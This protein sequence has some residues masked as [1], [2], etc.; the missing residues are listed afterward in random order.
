[1]VKYVLKRVLIGILTMLVLITATFFLMHIIP[2]SPFISDDDTAA[3]M[4]AYEALEAKYGLDKPYGE[5]YIIY[6]K[7]ILKGELG[8]SLIRKGQK[9]VDIIA[10]CAP[11]TAKL[12]ATAFIFSMVVGI[13]L[14]TIAAFA[15]RRLVNGVTM[16]ISTIGVSVP[17]FLIGADDILWSQAEA[18]AYN[19]A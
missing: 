13:T 5:Q 4:K 11:V 8:E 3:A 15:K 17:N 2:G 10:R 1:M 7:G 12:A 14:G 9:V 16:V 6:M 18:G 19:R